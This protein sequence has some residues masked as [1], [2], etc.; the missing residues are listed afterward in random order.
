MHMVIDETSYQLIKIMGRINGTGED[1]VKVCE[2]FV[3]EED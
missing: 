3:C 1:I 2:Y